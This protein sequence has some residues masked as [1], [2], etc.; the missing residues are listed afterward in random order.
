MESVASLVAIQ[1]AE[2]I[3]RLLRALENAREDQRR[4]ES[5]RDRYMDQA[6]HWKTKATQLANGVK[7]TEPQESQ[8]LVYDG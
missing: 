2:Q 5:D 1:Q 6:K 7:L 8:E 4:A 3:Q